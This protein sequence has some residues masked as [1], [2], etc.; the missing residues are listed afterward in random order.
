MPGAPR[1]F[2]NISPLV[3]TAAR[4]SR[5]SS[6]DLPPYRRDRLDLRYKLVYLNANRI[7]TPLILR[8]RKLLSSL[9][10]GGVLTRLI[11]ADV[12]GHGESV[13]ETSRTLRTQM[14]RFI[15][16]KRQERLIHNL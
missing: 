1:R 11:L 10:A 9:C 13:S 8:F 5:S 2:R 4:R 14:R 15:N 7:A 16:T 3:R 6:K 12:S